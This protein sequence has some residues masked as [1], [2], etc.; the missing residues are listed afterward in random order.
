[1]ILLKHKR[2]RKGEGENGELTKRSN[3]KPQK[4]KILYFKNFK[5]SS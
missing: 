4:V 2:R 1:M 3:Y 5:E